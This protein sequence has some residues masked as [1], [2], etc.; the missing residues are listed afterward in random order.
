METVVNPDST[1]WKGR[2]VFL[3]GHTGFKGSWLSVWLQEMGAVVRGYALDPP[4]DPSLFVQADVASGMDSLSGDIRDYDVLREA[5]TE[6][7]PEVVF[8]LAAQPLVR[9]SYR[10]PRETYEVNVMGT[11][12]VLE[13]V[14]AVDT[15]RSMVVVTTDKVYENME[16]HWGYRENDRLGGYDPYSNSKAGAELVVA[17]YRNSFFNLKTYGD[18]HN[19]AVATARAGNVIGGGDWATDRIVPDIMRAWLNKIPTSIRNP[20]AIRPWQHVLEP[21]SGYLVLAERL[22][23]SVE[24]AE[25]WNF[26]PR[27]TDCI[28]VGELANLFEGHCA[29]LVIERGSVFGPHEAGFLKLDISKASVRLNWK[30]RWTVRTAVE[31]TANE[32]QRLIE[33][34]AREMVTTTIGEYVRS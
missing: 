5:I 10:I 13:A 6:F 24:H 2:R 9:E 31:Q 11:V 25:Q 12:N 4:T 18:E 22:F 3:T 21:L 30:P 8:H 32:Y 29:G 16:W 23:D 1:F 28:P 7:R 34:R 14:R 27:D 26:G 20:Y 17:A 19:V 15:V 33:S